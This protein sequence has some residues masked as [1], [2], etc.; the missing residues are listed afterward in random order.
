MSAASWGMLG[1]SVG[2][3]VIDSLCDGYVKI[4]VE[5]LFL[6]HLITAFPIL[7]NPP[8]QF[9]EGLFGIPQKF[10]VTRVLFRLTVIAL[11]LLLALS[12]PVFGAILD[13]LLADSTGTIKKYE[14]RP[15]PMWV[16]IYSW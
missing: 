16:R 4:S 12:L 8:N 13:L 3:S 1:D 9:F 6:L 10:C 5:I 11:M 7:M 2:G 14:P 15:V